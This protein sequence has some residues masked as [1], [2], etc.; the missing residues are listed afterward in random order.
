MV[1]LCFSRVMFFINYYF[2]LLF[3]RFLAVLEPF[4]LGSRFHSLCFMLDPSLMWCANVNCHP[5][6]DAWVKWR[7]ILDFTGSC[8][9]HHFACVFAYSFSSLK[10]R[11]L[12]RQRYKFALCIKFKKFW[13]DS[14][15]P[16]F[17]FLFSSTF[18]SNISV[19]PLR[20]VYPTFKSFLFLF[21]FKD[22]SPLNSI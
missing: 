4:F 6:S 3:F 12:V 7:S 10:I 5:E 17:H 21:L 9:I 8:L 11:S 1:A 13:T 19:H 15:F 18:P 14:V 22:S 2:N 20:S 16:T